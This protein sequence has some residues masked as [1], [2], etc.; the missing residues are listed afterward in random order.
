MNNTI[1]KHQRLLTDLGK[2]Y[3][4][5]LKWVKKVSE[6]PFTCWQTGFGWVSSWTTC[7]TSTSPELF[8]E[9]R[10][11][12]WHPVKSAGTQKKVTV[13]KPPHKV[14]YVVM[15]QIWWCWIRNKWTYQTSV[16]CSSTH[17]E[18]NGTML[19][20]PLLAYTQESL[21]CCLS[22]CIVGNVGDKWQ[23]RIMLAMKNTIILCNA[24]LVAYF[25][26]KLIRIVSLLT[27]YTDMLIRYMFTDPWG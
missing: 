21:N 14:W 23:H 12:Y 10:K 17:L 6:F 27:S 22:C 8:R 11:E 18:A 15:K 26:L 24:V 1:F 25:F 20:K 4:Q 9:S 16:A 3:H 2:L 7:G 5:C 19:H 13:H